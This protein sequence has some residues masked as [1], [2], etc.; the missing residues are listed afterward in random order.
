MDGG[1]TPDSA[2]I[3]SATVAAIFDAIADSADR[4][5]LVRRICAVLSV[6]LD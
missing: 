1:G 6:S 2:G 4:Q 3:T 5:F